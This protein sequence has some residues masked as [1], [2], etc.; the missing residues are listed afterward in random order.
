MSSLG[1]AATWT[2]Q[3]IGAA[4]QWGIDKLVSYTKW[5]ALAGAA[6]ATWQIKKGVDWNAQLETM[7]VRLAA[8]YKSQALAN[9]EV[10]RFY[11][12]A[13]G[14][15]FNVS[16]I[17]EAT[18]AMRE[19][20][21]GSTQWLKT[22]MDTAAATGKSLGEV[23]H[24]M[25]EFA[26]GREMFAV[27]EF[28]GMGINVRAMPGLKWTPQ[29][30]L[31]NSGPEANAAL[32]AG[33]A[34]KFGG[35]T[36][37]LAATFSG[38]WK[39]LMENIDRARGKVTE[40]LFGA[41]RGVLERL[42]AQWDAIWNNPRVQR[43]LQAVGG[44]LAD[45]VEYAR[46]L[47][48]KFQSAFDKG[49]LGAGLK[50]VWDDLWPKVKPEAEAFIGWF[51]KTLYEALKAALSAAWHGTTFGEKAGIIG[52][53]AG[54]W[55]VSHPT[56]A[57]G[58]GKGIYR[59]GRA[60]LPY[61]GAAVRGIGGMVGT[62]GTAVNLGSGATG[63]MGGTGAL[64]WLGGQGAIG[65]G[66]AQ[67]IATAALPIAIAVA[68][69]LVGRWAIGRIAENYSG[70]V[71]RR[72][73]NDTTVDWNRRYHH[74]RDEMSEQRMVESQT[75]MRSVL[76]GAAA[77]WR[78]LL[79]IQE[80]M[81]SRLQLALDEMRTDAEAMLAK[82]RTPEQNAAALRDR[83][84]P[85]QRAQEK[86]LDAYSAAA[87]D[88]AAGRGDQVENYNRLNAAQQAFLSALAQEHRLQIQIFDVEEQRAEKMREQVRSVE[89]LN[90]ADRTRLLGLQAQFKGKSSSED[91][92]R[93][94]ESLT[95]EAQRL[96]R[97]ALSPDQKAML[98][99]YMAQKFGWKVETQGETL[100]RA[101]GMEAG[102]AVRAGMVGAPTNE[103]VAGSRE[104]IV[105]NAKK[106]LEVQAH[107]K[108]TSD[109]VRMVIALDSTDKANAAVKALMDKH[110]NEM[111]LAVD[112]ALREAAP[113][114][115]KAATEAAIK[116]V[117][118]QNYNAESGVTP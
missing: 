110:L 30:E 99:Q 61:A 92:G 67:F 74:A 12:L 117:H 14:T 52:G 88:I 80:R 35:T 6:F 104:Q 9:R 84:W 65:A 51:A 109:E 56:A 81:T 54:Y 26:A 72:I 11:Q 77:A 33:L 76:E 17:A 36:D 107:V 68:A 22:A 32:Q 63:M 100:K 82:F 78:E 18:R 108:V 55:A 102:F 37:R 42:N 111:K 34:G 94:F 71:D 49:G 113:E 28:M 59:A 48:A 13:H 58:V 20:G 53:L 112:K 15:P 95:P 4:L 19:F 87:Q 5:A 90:N 27:R 29:G 101:Q 46:R 64:G 98:D 25:S 91:I 40:G 66:A 116:A 2:G 60:V 1:S 85:F 96:S 38:Q 73:Q 114:I 75:N 70:N 62:A 43:I 8:L 10:A 44:A 23:T 50:A 41:L 106:Q 97:F 7:T 83:A 89:E 21:I 57:W 93:V 86:S 79:D 69:G 103:E 118:Q 24:A 31:K 105:E 16:E 45:A 39:I 3:K 115:R 47:A